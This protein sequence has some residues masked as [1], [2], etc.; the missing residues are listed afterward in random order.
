MN[1]KHYMNRSK[2]IPAIQPGKSSYM[3]GY[4]KMDPETIESTTFIVSRLMAT[5]LQPSLIQIFWA[6]SNSKTLHHHL[7]TA[8]NVHDSDL[9]FWPNQPKSSSPL[10]SWHPMYLGSWSRLITGGDSV[11]TSVRMHHVSVSSEV[12]V[13]SRMCK[14]SS[15]L[16]HEA[17]DLLHRPSYVSSGG[18][19]QPSPKPRELPKRL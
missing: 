4:G 16:D 19:C 3:L 15:S 17:C 6:P 7:P 14:S 8:E 9:A 1:L 13:V 5:R 2:R 11:I 12:V 18:A 10:R